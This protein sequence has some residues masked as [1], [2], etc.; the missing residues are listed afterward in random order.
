MMKRFL[1]EVSRPSR[2]SGFTLIELLV[3]IAIIAI[4]ISL[5]LPAVQQAREA[6]RRTQCKNNLHNLGLAA[7]NFEGTYKKLPPGQIFTPD[8]YSTY[9]LDHLSLV[10]TMAYLL[11][12]MEQDAI[13]A[14]FSANLKMDAADYAVDTVDVRKQSYYYYPAINLVT[15]FQSPALLCPS[16]NAAAALKPGSG[17]FTLWM[18]RTAGGPT[19]GGYVMND[20]PSD[21]ITSLHALTNY[22][23][24]AG[25]FVAT[26]TQLGYA[27]TDPLYRGVNDYAG[28][29]ELNKQTKFADVNDGLSNTIMFGEITGDFSDGYKGVGRLRSFSWLIGPIGTHYMGPNNLAGT[30]W[31]PARPTWESNKFTSRHVGVVQYCLGDGSV[32]A[33][34]TNTDYDVLLRLGG[35]ADGL[36]VSGVE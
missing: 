23:G 12:Y 13:F 30:A 9:N 3:V 24:C 10:G 31:V 15:K 21:P 17:D 35:K 4:L 14:P 11:P 25:R 2:R 7:H 27:T 26:G 22:T 28:M 1:P 29:L 33:L 36:I 19:Y 20:V 8:A 16:D 18:I 5:L 6:A 32:R 34:S